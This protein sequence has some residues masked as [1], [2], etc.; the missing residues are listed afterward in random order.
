MKETPAKTCARR[1]QLARECWELP[2]RGA[3]MG[4]LNVTPDSFSDGGLHDSVPA[5]LAHAR[6]LVEQ[7]ADIIDVGGEST[8]PGSAEVEVE[9]ELRRTRPVIEALRAEFPALRIS[10]D[11]RHAEVARAALL[12][13]A[14]V[15]NDITG[16]ADAAMRRVCA[17]M[18]CGVVLMHMQGSPETMQH[19][20][21]YDDVVAEV[22]A[23]FEQRVAQAVA[24]GIALSRICLDPGIGIAFGKTTEHNLALIRHLEM[25]R[26]HDLPMLMALSR[27]R[28]LGE[29]L[30]DATLA[31]ECALPTVAMSLLA[32]DRGA[33]M[34][35]VHDV[36]P[37]CQ[38]LTLRNAL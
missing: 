6:L 22:R 38:A 12:A 30:G 33:D 34:H 36:A 7:G 14:D 5:A 26:V 15:V 4:I 31:K 37:L 2:T 35:R 25:L 8:R 24:D 19:A 10:I 11:T 29:L 3:V 18:P 28:F 9:E 20:P 16:L 21:H 17:E 23:F 1:W 27:K 32:A 13:G